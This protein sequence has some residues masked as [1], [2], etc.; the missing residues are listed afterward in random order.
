VNGSLAAALLA[1]AGYSLLNLGQAGQKIGLG[2]RGARP[3]AG[4]ILWAAATLSTSLAFFVVFAAISIGAVSVVGAM[5]GTGL[6]SLAIFGRLV[7]GERLE[8]KHLVSL[9]AIVAGAA[10][11]ALFDANDGADA[12][13]A[14]LGL[15]WASLG[16]GTLAYAVSWFVLRRGP[17]AGVIL[18]GLSG[19]LGAYSQ[20]FQELASTDL[21]WSE[22]LP[23][24]ASSVLRDPVT[25]VWAGLSVVSMVVIQFSYRHGE[26][27][28]IIPVFTAN[29]ILVPVVGGVVVFGQVLGIVQWIGVGLILVGSIVLGRA[30]G[31]AG[32]AEADG[33][34]AERRV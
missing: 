12:G 15:L 9:V 14:R 17:L 3:V 21:K 25:L 4:W 19:F 32:L 6:V 34:V 33:S 29:F 18:G 11:I 10:L 2:L 26:A 22:G 7:M 13:P 24:V 28:R 23:A 31:A 20:L 1:F 16:G 5:A 8:A 27:T 30:R